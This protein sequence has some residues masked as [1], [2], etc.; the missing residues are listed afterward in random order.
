MLLKENLFPKIVESSIKFICFP[1][2]KLSF[3][4]MKK[5][6][7]TQNNLKVPINDYFSLHFL[8]KK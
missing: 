6:L 8:A 7:H 5:Y 4:V 3:A 2:F 1:D